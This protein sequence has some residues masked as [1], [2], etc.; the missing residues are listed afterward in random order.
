MDD[1]QLKELVEGRFTGCF[2]KMSL[3]VFLVGLAGFA[4]MVPMINRN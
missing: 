4:M 2:L 1:L 3:M